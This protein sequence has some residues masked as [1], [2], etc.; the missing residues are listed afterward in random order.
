MAATTPGTARMYRWLVVLCGGLGMF[1]VSMDIAVNVSLP[2]ITDHFNTDRQTIQWI[3]VSFVVTRAG[4]AVA[5]GSFGD[6]FGLKRV[7]LAG[8][9]CYT[10]AI[11]LIAF[12]PNL[13]SVFGFRVLQGIG[14]GGLYAVSPA[15]AGRLFSGDQRGMVMGVTTA[16]NALGTI[17]GTLGAGALVGAFGWEAAFLGRL[18]ICIVAILLGWLALKDD[19][20]RID[21][22]SFDLMGAATLVAGIVA[23]V[24][25]LH[26]GGRSGWA[27]PLVVGFLVA[28]PLLL[29]SFVYT[30]LRARWPVLDLRLLRLPP[31]LAACAGMFV[32]QMGVFVVWFVF[33]FY[34]ADALGR[35]PLFL[36]AMMAI[37]AA[38]MSLASP[39]AGWLSDRTRPQYVALAGIFVIAFGLAW[40]G[41]LDGAS[42]VAEV[43]SRIAV[44]GVG[45]GTFLAA[46]YSLA[47]KALPYDRF[48]TG[49]G[50]L[51]L[52]QA[53]GWVVS[54]AL[55]GLAF[56]ILT[57]H[58]MAVLDA[59]GIP[60]I[61]TEVEA[62]VEAFK[63]TFHLA[64]L[65]AVMGVGALLLGMGV[66]FRRPSDNSPHQT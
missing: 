56:A 63:G 27:S 66:R 44:V 23:L 49:S 9:L 13:A 52:A 58:H 35:G 19:H 31:F 59:Q 40:M 1:L 61:E 36:G 30:E 46:A 18:P 64:A 10:L 6:L 39:L 62:L 28:A 26:I 22:L 47:L 55:G 16:S 45:Q 48:G 42:S 17:G 5:L 2:T 14:A 4:L 11:I 24:L 37:M 21:G 3:I 12:S 41:L 51:S 57:D 65:V 53:M 54:V 29:A 15:I 50:T 7:F 34:V 20:A 25:A 43:G 38:A 33:P 32:V 60:A 8:T